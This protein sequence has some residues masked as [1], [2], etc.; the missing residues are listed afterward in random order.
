MTT[1]TALEHMLSVEETAAALSVHRRTVLR[2]I[3]KG[4]LPGAVHFPGEWRI[5][6]AT[7]DDFIERRTV[8]CPQGLPSSSTQQ[9]NGRQEATG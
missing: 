1:H 2:Y 5:P 3:R 4:E 7:V 8:G 9:G 6:Q